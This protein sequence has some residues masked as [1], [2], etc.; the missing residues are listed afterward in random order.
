M[1]IKKPRTIGRVEK[2][3]FP[4]FN[5]FEIDAKVDTGAYTSAIHCHDI[6]SF[7]EDEQE[8]VSFKLLDPSHPAYNHKEIKLPVKARRNIKN[9]FGQVQK[10]IIV[11]ARMRIYD[12]TYKVELSLADRSKLEYPV[13]LGR[14]ALYNRFIVDVSQKN[15]AYN[16]K[17]HSINNEKTTK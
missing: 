11:Q 15:M 4:D 17:Q 2:I 8:M 6:V 12:K 10:R 1:K 9:S 13:L 5:L 7:K 16:L 3:D 14:K